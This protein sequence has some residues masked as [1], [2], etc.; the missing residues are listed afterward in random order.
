M[1]GKTAKKQ[2]KRSPALTQNNKLR[3]K[4]AREKRALKRLGLASQK[5]TQR[6]EF[7]RVKRLEDKNWGRK[8]PPGDPV[9]KHEAKNTESRAV[10]QVIYTCV[11]IPFRD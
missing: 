1:P 2:T 9:I 5:R 6:R 8:L 11:V 10:S 3:Q 7:L 4:K